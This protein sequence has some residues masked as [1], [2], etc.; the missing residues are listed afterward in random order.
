MKKLKKLAALMLCTAMTFMMC[1]IVSSAASGQLR[2][3][4][5]STTVGATVE[6]TAKLSADESLSKASATLTYDTTALKF[7]S[8]ENATA[9]NGQIEL[10]GSGSGNTEMSWT[11]KFQAL[12]EGTTTVNISKVTASASSGDDVTVVEGSSTVTI[13]E[14]DPSLI[15]DD[16]ETTDSSG[17][18]GDIEIDGQT[19]SVVTDIPEVLIPDGF[20]TADM[21]YNGNTYAATKQESGK[22]YAIYLKDAN[23]EEDF[24]LYDPDKDKFSPFE[25]VSISSNRYIVLLSEDKTKD[26]PDTLQ[27]TTMTVE[28]KEFPAWQNTDASSYYVVYAVNS[29]GEEG[30]YQYDTVDETYQR[31]TPETKDKEEDTT[32][33]GGLLNKLRANL[34]KVILVAWGIFLVMLIILIILAIKLRHRN[35]EL[36]D[37]YEEYDIDDEPEPVKESKKEKKA[38]KKAEKEAK[39]SKKSKKKSE[40]DFYDFD[41]EDDEYDLDDDYEDEMYEDEDD[42]DE[43]DEYEEEPFKEYNPSDYEDDSDIDDLDEILNARVRV[44]KSAPRRTAQ[45]SARPKSNQR[46][47]GHSEADD[48]FK[49]DLIDLD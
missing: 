10:E 3:S 22:M 16:E 24:W 48:T 7:I 49:M 45:T 12:S 17:N 32:K 5:P 35:L 25:Q 28:G 1:G 42:Y 21:P 23:E 33:L 34:D 31:Y 27:K 36:D 39:K 15:T 37:L 6:I 30:F 13:G 14:G 18:G 19:Y 43:Y 46:R 29:D 9:S 20:V 47:V 26:L 41:D 4:D 2:F 11:L 38:R 44:K 40:D 8:G